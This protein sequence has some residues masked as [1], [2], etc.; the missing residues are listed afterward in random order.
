MAFSLRFTG[1]R[2]A[3]KKFCSPSKDR[4]ATKACVAIKRSLFPQATL[5]KLDIGMAQFKANRQTNAK[6][7]LI[8]KL[9]GLTKMPIN[10]VP[11][12]NWNCFFFPRARNV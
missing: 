7:N 4:V 6:G 12:I 10:E 5:E 9:R 3:Q 8:W 1:K 11:R 2:S